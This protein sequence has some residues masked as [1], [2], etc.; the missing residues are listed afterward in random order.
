MNDGLIEADKGTAHCY[1]SNYKHYLF[2]M[3][4][5]FRFQLDKTM[6]EQKSSLS[7]FWPLLK[8]RAKAQ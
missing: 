4:L 3:G 6:G 7:W 5:M 8:C 2:F 1:Q